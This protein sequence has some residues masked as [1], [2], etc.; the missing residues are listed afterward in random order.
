MADEYNGWTNK[1]TWLV[2]LWLTNEQDDDAL[3]RRAVAAL[4]ARGDHPDNFREYVE[5][6]VLGDE[7]PASL[8]TDLVMAAL[9]R[10]NWREVVDALSEGVEA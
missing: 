4:R 3:A 2:H 10:V 1:E 9:G 8:G 7:A 5:G 6:V